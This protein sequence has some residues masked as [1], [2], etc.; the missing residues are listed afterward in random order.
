VLCLGS[1]RAMS[2]SLPLAKGLRDDLHRFPPIF[3]SL[4]LPRHH[5][6]DQLESSSVILGEFVMGWLVVRAFNS[7]WGAMRRMRIVSNSAT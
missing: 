3:Y 5:G 6:F 4:T 1:P 2:R 7:S